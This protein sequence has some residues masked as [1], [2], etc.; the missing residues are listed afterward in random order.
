MQLQCSVL[1]S[2]SAWGRLFDCIVRTRTCG[3]VEENGC[4]GGH[5]ARRGM[6][7]RHRTQEAAFIVVKGLSYKARS[8]P[9]SRIHKAD[10]RV[11]GLPLLHT[12][13]EIGIRDIG[14]SAHRFCRVISSGILSTNDCQV[15]WI[16]NG[17]REMVAVFSCRS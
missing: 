10:K 1:L 9:T 5:D 8:K 12:E 3:T 11:A 15:S 4:L 6:L 17:R 13:L 7:W 16:S 14:F 2:H